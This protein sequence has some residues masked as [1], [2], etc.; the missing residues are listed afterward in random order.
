MLMHIQNKKFTSKFL[1]QAKNKIANPSLMIGTKREAIISQLSVDFDCEF[2]NKNLF[3][4][5]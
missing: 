5:N 2:L 3:K 4:Q 1:S